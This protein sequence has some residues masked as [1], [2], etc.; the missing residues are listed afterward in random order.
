M[1]G[2]QHAGSNNE[3][4]VGSHRNAMGKIVWS[5]MQ[6]ASTVGAVRHQNCISAKLYQKGEAHLTSQ[7]SKNN[8]HGY[9]W[10]GPWKIGLIHK[11]YDFA[12]VDLSARLQ[13]S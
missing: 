4:T 3:R 11:S 10:Y 6:F 1:V 7:G 13:R 9:V 2:A 12:G 5:T 8:G